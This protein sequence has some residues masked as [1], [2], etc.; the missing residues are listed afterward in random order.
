[1]VLL[2]LLAKKRDLELVVA[3]FNHGIRADSDKDEELVR[4]TAKK[5]GIEFVAGH[6][7]LGARASEEQAREAR[8]SFLNAVK[9][10]HRAKTMITAHHQDDLIETALIN[11][12][13]GSGRLG[14]TS[15][16]DNPAI[17]RPLLNT[18]KKDILAY[19]AEHKVVW[20]ED[21]SNLDPKYLRNYLRLNILPRLTDSQRQELLK[22]IESVAKSQTELNAL[23]ATI[24]HNVISHKIID[25]GKYLSL[26][27]PLDYELMAYW[28]RKNVGGDF[29]RKTVERLALGMK[30]AKPGSNLEASRGVY[31]VIGAKGA[32]FSN[33]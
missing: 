2:D 20:R 11:V 27:S 10:Q 16:L 23:I 28:L 30:T 21:S 1:M 6:G 9:R 5:L 14:L 32:Q 4:R 12:L 26:P 7:R 18:P 25:R 22:N 29:N 8:Y 13:R 17:L 24:S 3:H 33:R 15:M 19:A 31:L